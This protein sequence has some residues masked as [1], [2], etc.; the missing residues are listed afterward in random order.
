MRRNAEL[1]ALALAAALS[2]A[3]C[4]AGGGGDFRSHFG[5]GGLPPGDLA[6][7]GNQV[8]QTLGD[9]TMGGY[10]LTPA[11]TDSSQLSWD[12]SIRI[13]DFYAR[14]QSGE[15]TCL[16]IT[17]GATW[18]SAC[19]DEQ[20]QLISDVQG[21]P[22]FCVLGILQDGPNTGV[23][24]TEADVSDWTQYFRQNFTVAR[25][26]NQSEA[27]FNGWDSGGTIGLPFSLIVKP[28]TMQV[29]DSMQGF[30]ADIHSI[31][32]ADCGG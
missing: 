26:S 19:Q 30:S 23:T 20:P 24:A 9:F 2:L 13:A 28:Q 16:L 11:Q 15:C 10:R 27:L 18:C 17:V 31:A 8:G 25:G 3:A 14:A 7:H 32:R 12:P 21:D 29:L 22:T 5:D 4:S 1:V 6:M